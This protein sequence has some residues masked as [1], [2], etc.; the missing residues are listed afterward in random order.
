M[1]LIDIPF[2]KDWVTFGGGFIVVLFTIL[3]IAPIKLNPW[4]TILGWL[5]DRLNSNLLKRI[6]SVEKKLDQHIEESKKKELA[7]TRS[8]ILKFAN[9][10]MRGVKHT[11]EQFD[12]I[13]ARCD[14]YELHIEKNNIRNGVIASAI[15][16]IRRI[17]DQCIQENDFLK[18][19]D[20]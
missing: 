10:C 14:E 1:K 16:E 5:G 4:D 19:N 11:R 12:F 13:I 8:D 20:E 3:Q 6:A 7:D 9:E 17:Y 15:K 2:I 18:E